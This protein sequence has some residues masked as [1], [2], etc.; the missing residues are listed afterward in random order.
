MAWEVIKIKGKPL[1]SDVLA[2]HA[3]L[4]STNEILYFGGDEHYKDQH[5]RGEIDNTRLF[6]V[7]S[8]LIT[9]VSSPTTDIFC[10]GHAFLADGRLLVGGGT[11]QW[12]VER[13]DPGH[14]HDLNFGGHRACWI[15]DPQI[16]S[17]K[18]WVRVA[19]MNFQPGRNTGGGR[20]YPTLITL[21]SGEILAVFGHPRRTD[22]RHRNGTPERYSPTLNNWTLLPPIDSDI[23]SPV[24]TPPGPLLNY[25]RLHVLP[26]GTI[27]FAT[28]VK[29]NRFYDPNTGR[30]VG[31]IITASE[32]IRYQDW[33]TTSVL[34]PLLPNDSYKPCVLICGSVQPRRINLADDSPMWEPAGERT[35]AAAGRVRENLCAVILPT[36]DIFLS[37]GVSGG[38]CD[39]IDGETQCPVLHGEIY[40]PGIDWNTGTYTGTEKWSSVEPATVPRNYHSVALLMPDGRV[41]TAGSS[42]NASPGDPAV[43]GEMRIEVFKPD[44]YGNPSRPQIT[45]SPNS[46]SY[47]QSFSVRTMQAD[48]ESIQR[49]ALVRAGSVTHAFDA[50]QRY[51]ALQFTSM[52]DT[53]LLVTA[54]P[55][56]NVAP[57]GYYLLFIINRHNV[58]SVGRF[59]SVPSIGNTLTVE[60]KLTFLRVHDVGTKFGHPRDQIDV[61]VVIKLDSEPDKAFGFQLRNDRN[62]NVHRG[63]L[64]L[65]RYAFNRDQRVRIEYVQTGLRNNYILHIIS[66]V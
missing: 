58:P 1:S 39:P 2:I 45:H 16:L 25:P 17:K 10:S 62:E 42:K 59:I 61:E 24:D 54:P 20:W 34:L 49:V 12:G 65:L 50:D 18:K 46:V 41:W 7:N 13:D 21:P 51:I 9:P 15:F 44:Y 33:Y 53:R 37:G 43:V 57:P 63:M 35:G 22:T 3:A 38:T 29:G 19:N 47:G 55:N 40:S 66:T 56:P 36:G 48:T 28:P 52:D 26:N 8:N 14:P 27:F 30:F 11:E 64:N 31:P 60:G 23:R 32:D 4:L 5:D 6:D